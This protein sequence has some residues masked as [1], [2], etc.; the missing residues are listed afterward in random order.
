MAARRRAAAPRYVSKPGAHGTLYRFRIVYRD[1]DDPGFPESDWLA[2]AYDAEH[3]EDKFYD[4]EDAW[5]WKIVSIS[6]VRE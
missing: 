6:R 3:A 5:G 2:W 1:L 4:S